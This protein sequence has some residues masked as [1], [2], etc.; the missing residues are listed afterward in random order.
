MDKNEEILNNINIYK[1][2]TNVI[3]EAV[4]VVDEEG[5]IIKWLNKSKEMFGY[6]PEETKGKQF[7]KLLDI[8]ESFN[9]DKN[10]YSELS[11]KDK[12]GDEIIISLNIESASTQSETKL[13]IFSCLD[14]TEQKKV[15]EGMNEF[16]DNFSQELERMVKE[17]T[18]ELSKANHL[19]EDYSKNLEEKVEQRTSQ[20][21][22]LNKELTQRNLDMMKELE[23]AKR[24]QGSIIPKEET[25][26]K[27]DELRFG[28]YYLAME[29]IGGDIYDIIRAG[30]N[31]YAL[32]MGD[33]SGHGVPAALI[34]TM[35]KVSFNTYTHWNTSTAE[36][37]KKV[38][39]DVCRLIRDLDYYLTAYYGI[40]NLETGE[41]TYTNASHHP[42]ILYRKRT[43]AIEKLDSEGFLIGAFEDVNFGE[44]KVF[45]EEGDR[46]LM[47]T[48]G[49]IEAK[50]DEGEF[51]E[52]ERLLNYV[53]SNSSLSPKDF[54][55]GLVK[56]LKSF[57]KEQS[58]NDD[59]AILYI[60]LVKKITGK[61]NGNTEKEQK[62][63]SSEFNKIYYE[64]TKYMKNKNYKEALTL[65]EKLNEEDPENI[66][67]LNN[68]GICYYKLGELRKAL[69]V[70]QK[71]LEI[72]ENNDKIKKNLYRIKNHIEKLS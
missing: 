53:E 71:A 19:L 61:S 45:L 1:E 56:D 39:E 4:I 22:T 34:T 3:S 11:C 14:I 55:S 68:L 48:D 51:Y 7:W 60:E 69:N 65:N 46:L 66:H 38:N 49:I 23:M 28:S 35:V 21:K 15:E 59:I 33:V 18:E 31:G 17:R 44:G 10:K 40:I 6:E 57:T 54:V 50:N 29:S 72:D 25:F 43:K 67:V 5:K 64:A 9:I 37:C 63:I 27:R 13:Y 26:P 58:Q 52:Y 8:E 32:L 24:V 62:K 12:K 20:L 2:V 42:T 30:R 16:Y 36:V 70:F 47:F 41:F